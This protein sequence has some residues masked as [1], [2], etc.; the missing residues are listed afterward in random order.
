[1]K[2]IISAFL[3]FVV[4]ASASMAVAQ[5]RPSN[6]RS[7]GQSKGGTAPRIQSGASSTSSHRQGASMQGPNQ[8]SHGMQ[9]AFRH[10]LPSRPIGP[11]LGIGGSSLRVV[12][13]RPQTRWPIGSMSYPLMRSSWRSINVMPYP[14]ALTNWQPYDLPPYQSV[15]AQPPV[16]Q[17]P[18]IDGTW[19]MHGDGNKPARIV[20]QRLDGRALFINE[21]GSQAW[22]TVSGDS[23]YIPDW[24]DGV[25]QGL[26]GVLRGTRIIWPDGNYWSRIPNGY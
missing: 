1:M 4:P 9:Q 15:L 8:Q 24:S 13:Q 16:A 26:V 5:S 19:Y 20:Q 12:Q 17:V 6:P 21:N 14:I 25:N 10:G 3:A 2:I 18:T 23:V 22:G 7:G 11:A